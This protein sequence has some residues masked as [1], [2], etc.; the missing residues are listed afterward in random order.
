MNIN[1]LIELDQKYYMNTFGP[2]FP[3]S[4]VRGEKTK[5][6]SSEGREY[7]DFLA[8]IAVNSLGYAHPEFTER[9]CEQIKGVIHTSNYYYIE[10][11]AKLA[12]ALVENS[13]FDRVF[14]ANSGSEANEGA[15]KLIRKYHNGKNTGRFEIISAHNSFHGRTL[16][17]VAATGQKKYQ[18][19]YL[20]LPA[21]FIQVDFNDFTA[22]K[23]AVTGRTAAV[24]LEVIQGEGG[25]I[26]AEPEFLKQ[27]E[28]LCRENGLLLV[29]DEVQTGMGRTGKLFGYEHYGIHPDIIT[30]AKAL[31]NGV[32]IGAILAKESVCAFE[33]GNHGTTFGGNPLACA[34][35]LAVM[36]ILKNEGLIEIAAETGKYFKSELEKLAA[37]H[38]AIKEIRG[39]GLMLG[40]ELDVSIPGKEIVKEMLARGYIIN[41][42][43]HNT[44]RFVPPLIITKTEIDSML[45]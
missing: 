11:Q 26:E 45:S 10:N 13:E 15:I 2:R 14:F 24:F 1:D 38:T 22:M 16:A 6:Y 30:L 17:M 36:D 29:I 8:G 33:P 23:N 27:V 40:C 12:Q 18:A 31:G 42:S 20:P 7:T 19:P 34:A 41:C 43:G 37:K 35:G 28:A 4:F 9:L 32:P 39:K 21:G 25:V 44:L 3:V 5:L